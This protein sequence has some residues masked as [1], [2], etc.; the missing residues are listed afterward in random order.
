MQERAKI[1]RE[2]IF[3]ASVELFSSKGFHGTRVDEVAEKAGV[4]KQ[5]IYAYFGNKSK[6]FETCLK[7][8][9]EEASLFSKKSLSQAAEAPEQLTSMLLEDFMSIHRK[10][11]H[12]WRM[13]AWANLDEDIP[14]EILKG[15]R[16]SE[17]QIILETFEKAQDCGHIKKDLSFETYIFTLMAVSYFYTSNKKTL[18]QS[19]SSSI[20]SPLG[21]KKLKTEVADLFNK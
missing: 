1:T 19:L 16:S 11:P 13:L 20:Y 8:V 14:V 18:S 3:E 17:D 15:I 7:K 9:F 12:F 10:Y 4:N 6:L 2:K 21:R 5:R